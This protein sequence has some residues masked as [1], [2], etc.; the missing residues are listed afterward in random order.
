MSHCDSSH[1]LLSIINKL[2]VGDDLHLNNNYMIGNLDVEAL[3]PLLDIEKCASVV[4]D[5]LYESRITF[6]NLQCEKIGLYL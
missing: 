4:G 6:G 3:F 2:N 5:K 1:K